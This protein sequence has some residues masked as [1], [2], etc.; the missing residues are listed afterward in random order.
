M[1]TL[2]VLI[3]VMITII[4]VLPWFAFVIV[5]VGYCYYKVQVRGDKAAMDGR[6]KGG[7]YCRCTADRTAVVPVT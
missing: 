2:S 5:P 7:R 1:A 4:I 3:G 6:G